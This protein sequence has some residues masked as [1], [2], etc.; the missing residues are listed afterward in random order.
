MTAKIVRVLLVFTAILILG[1]YLPDLFR[2]RFEKRAG[3]RLL[4]YSEVKRDFVFSEEVYDSLRQANRMVYYDRS[5]N[6]L[7]ENEYARLLPF[8]N[9]R[10]LKML[11]MMPDSLMGEPLTQE[12]LRSV[13]RV[14]LIGDRGF[15]FALAPLFESCPGHPGVDLP[16]DLFRIGR[17]GIGVHRRGD[18]Q[19]RYTEEPDFRRGAARS[20][21]PCSGAGHLRHPFDDQIPR[22]RLFRGRRPRQTVSFADGPRRT[23]REGH[24]QRFRDQAG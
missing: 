9:A 22:R 7:T 12:V 16:H 14:M 4:Y 15:D 24:R 8:D 2:S 10:K 19:R 6:P 13:R 21:V 17:R 20:R 3:K 5:G 1:F 23:A 18:E 11:G